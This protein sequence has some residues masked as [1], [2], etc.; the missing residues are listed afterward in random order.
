MIKLNKVGD[1]WKDWEIYFKGMKYNMGSGAAVD[2]NL[3]D[4]PSDSELKISIMDI[5][6]LSFLDIPQELYICLE[7]VNNSLGY[8]V[9][10]L[11]I[12]CRFQKVKLVYSWSIEVEA[13]SDPLNPVLL[14]NEAH[15]IL[16]EKSIDNKLLL[17]KIDDMDAGYVDLYFEFTENI[18]ANIGDTID[19]IK[20]LL[21]ET[22]ELARLKVINTSF[23]EALLAKFSFDPVVQDSCIRY[24]HFFI[25]FLKD[26]GIHADSSINKKG[27]DVLFSISPTSKEASLSK[28]KEV[29]AMYLN[30]PEFNLGNYDVSLLDPVT[31]LKIE[32][33]SAEIS[34]LKTD[35][36]LNQAILKY[37]QAAIS[38][39]KNITSKG[40]YQ[41]PS[42]GITPLTGLETITADNKVET[43][44]EFLG[45]FI[46]LGIFKKAGVEFDWAKL[47]QRLKK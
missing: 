32:K 45:G 40:L 19:T 6:K 4:F 47:A 31:E 35:I 3:Y 12:D 2:K 34:R 13:W 10:R 24:L 26:M 8:A 18:N 14:R 5:D 7:N 30:L 22:Y 29:L 42:L 11:W 37:E 21:D 1:S 44:E 23:P 27:C 38:S 20:F 46:K 28:I 17:H 15:K 43:K 36:K 41:N 25:E 33:I 9:Q 39:E 16:G